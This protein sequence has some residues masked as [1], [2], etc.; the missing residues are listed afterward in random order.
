VPDPLAP[1][2]A[3]PG[4]ILPS[5]E[6]A[7]R[8]ERQ[9]RDVAQVLS[10]PAVQ[11]AALRVLMERVQQP[12]PRP[13][14]HRT[15]EEHLDQAVRA[16]RHFLFHPQQPRA[17]TRLDIASFIAQEEKFTGEDDD[18]LETLK[19]RWGRDRRRRDER[20]ITLREVLTVARRGCIS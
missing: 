20:P 19:S 18:F 16:A 15:R 9:F 4:V 14:P 11:R 8:L 12:T 2:R 17:P 5:P 7:E 3:I 13:R 1:F 6:E 10:S